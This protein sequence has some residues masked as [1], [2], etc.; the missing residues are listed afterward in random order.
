MVQR[1]NHFVGANEMVNYHFAD[2]GKMIVTSVAPTFRKG[3][4]I[5]Y[6]GFS[7]NITRVVS[8]KATHTYFIPRP[9]GR[10]N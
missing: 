9:E 1:F 3:S 8:A 4:V 2:I 7:Q 10:G 6:L 5:R